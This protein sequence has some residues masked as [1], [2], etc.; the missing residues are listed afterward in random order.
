MTDGGKIR[1]ATGSIFLCPP[2]GGG[3]RRCG[4]F[5]QYRNIWIYKPAGKCCSAAN[6]GVEDALT[7][8]INFND[9]LTFYVK[10]GDYI[11]RVS[12][13]MAA[14]TLLNLVVTLIKGKK[15]ALIL[16]V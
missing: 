2:A 7:A 3:N 9:K 4:P 8:Q 13:F 10:H 6:G 12:V 5:G 16:I 1:P 15:S 14:L 11:A